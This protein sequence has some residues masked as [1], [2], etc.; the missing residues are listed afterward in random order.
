MKCEDKAILSHILFAVTIH[1]ETMKKSI[2]DHEPSETITGICL[3]GLGVVDTVALLNEDFADYRKLSASNDD[4]DVQAFL[5]AAK[6][7]Y[8]WMHKNGLILESIPA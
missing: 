3:Y 6:C 5:A 7:L 2:D 8:D 4:N 1:L